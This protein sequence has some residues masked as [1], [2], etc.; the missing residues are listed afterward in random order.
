[1]GRGKDLQPRKRRPSLPLAERIERFTDKSGGLD[2]CWP[3]TGGSVARG[4]GVLAINKHTHVASR[5]VYEM[6]HGPIPDGQWVLHRCDNP[7][8]VNP[9]HLFLG[10]P[11]Q[12]TADMCDKGR[13]KVGARVDQ[14]GAANH[15]AKFTEAQ[16]LEIRAQHGQ[17]ASYAHLARRYGCSG[18]A[19]SA[20]CRRRTWAHL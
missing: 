15:A 9:A 20:I 2:A 17:G 12:N 16:V 4:Y 18:G 7:P 11:H 19:I 13:A 5:V 1:M 10:T 3:W 14:K 8:C 6:H